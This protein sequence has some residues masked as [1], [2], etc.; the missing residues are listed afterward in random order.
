MK[1]PSS[2]FG[3]AAKLLPAIS[4]QK[5]PSH[6]DNEVLLDSADLNGIVQ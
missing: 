6:K 4:V 5:P 3:V 1:L 2:V